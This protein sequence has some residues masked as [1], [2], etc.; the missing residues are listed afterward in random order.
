M[1]DRRAV[2]EVLKAGLD[3]ADKRI[4]R[5]VRRRGNLGNFAR[6]GRLVEAE[7][8][9]EGAAD[10]DADDK[11]VGP[12]PC[13]WSFP[14]DTAK[15][16]GRNLI[17]ITVRIDHDAI[18]VLGSGNTDIPGA[19][20]AADRLWIAFIGGAIATPAWRFDT[21]PLPFFKFD[22][23]DLRHQRRAVLTII[24]LIGKPVQRTWATTYDAL[25]RKFSALAE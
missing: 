5:V 25:R 8:V 22:I 11:G 3:A 19:N 16:I 7:D 6:A 4:C 21:N 9:G 1:N 15:F 17:D 20:V 12:A 18:V 23:V 10:I 14:R 13:L 24:L 2:A